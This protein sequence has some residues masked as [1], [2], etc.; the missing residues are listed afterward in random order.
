MA[1]LIQDFCLEQISQGKTFHIDFAKRSLRVGK[2][3]LIKDGKVKGKDRD[4]NMLYMYPFGDTIEDFLPRLADLY[5]L[6][7]H[8]RPSA[9][10]EAHRRLYFDA[11]PLDDLSND[12]LVY[13]EPREQRR[14][15]LEFYILKQIISGSITWDIP[16]TSPGSW[17][18]QHPFSKTNH[19][20]H[21]DHE[22]AGLVLLRQWVKPE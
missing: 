6:Y 15:L 16:L 17:F 7:R 1:T 19:P 22:Y 4:G 11:I 13:G 9:R 14:F 3:T 12:D 5:Y 21:K 10:S 2:R 18:W 8:S 20:Q